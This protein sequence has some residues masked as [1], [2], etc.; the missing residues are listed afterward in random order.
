MVRGNDSSHNPSMTPDGHYVVFESWANNLVPSDTNGTA[1]VLMKDTVTGTLTRV[2]TDSLG[3]QGN[4]HSFYPSISS[5]GRF[6]AFASGASNLVS[7]DTNSRDDVFV[8]DLDTGSIRRVSV[9][10][11]D[12]G[13]NDFSNEPIVSGDGQFVAFA[14]RAT[15]LHAYDN[16]GTN[17]IFRA[18]LADFGDAPDTYGTTMTADGARHVAT[19]LLLGGERDIDSD[20]QLPLDG[21]GD[22]VTGTPDD[23]DGVTFTPMA[24]G[25]SAVV[26][27]TVSGGAGLLDAW[28]DFDGSGT[29][30]DPSERITAAGGTVVNVGANPIMVSI[31]ASAASGVTY[32][33]F[34]LSTT[35]GL[36]PT[37]PASDGEVEDYALSVA[38]P[39]SV[40]V[41]ASWAGTPIGADPPGPATAYG[42]DAF[43]NLPDGVAIVADTGTVN[44]AAGTYVHTGQLDI[45]RAMTIVGAG[46][47]VTIVKR[48]GAATSHEQRTVQIN[49]DNVTIQSLTLG[50]WVDPSDDGDIGSGYL[51]W[52]SSMDHVTFDDVRFDADDNRVAIYTGTSDYLTVTNSRFTGSYFRAGI[53]GAGEHMNISYNSFEESHY[54]YSPIYMEYG[55]PTSGL[56]S[57]NYFANRVGVNNDVEGEFKSDGT[58]LY[59]ITNWQPHMVTA[60]GLRIEYNTFDFQDSDLVNGAGNQPIPVGVMNDPALTASGPITI[61]DNIFRGYQYTGSQPSS[62]T[63]WQ[64]SARPAPYN[65][66]LAFD[67]IAEHAVF[68]SPLL[69][70]GEEGTIAF[71]INPDDVSTQRHALINGGGIEVTLRYGTVYFYPNSAAGDS[72]LTYGARYSFP[73]N[74]WTHVAV[75]WNHATQSTAIYFNGVESGYYSS[76]TPANSSWST[77]SD[78]AGKDIYVGYDPNNGDRIYPGMMDDLGFFDEELS[79]VEVASIMTNGVSSLL[80]DG[81][82]VAAWTLD[83]SSGEV[84]VDAENSIDLQLQNSSPTFVPTGGQIDGALDF[85]ETAPNFG[86]F[87]SPSYDVGSSGTLA[88]WVKPTDVG[89]QRHQILDGGGMGFTIRNSDAYFYAVSGDDDTLTYTNDD[90]IA[91]DT[92]THLAFTWDYATKTTHIYVN[93][94]EA[95][96]DPSYGSARPGWDTE[97]NTADQLIA[98]GIDFSHLDRAFPGLM[99]DIGVFDQPLSQTDIQ[100]VM[101]N[102][103]VALATD[104]RLVTHWNLD[105]APGTLE[106]PSDNGAAITLHL[107]DMAPPPATLA[108]AIKSSPNTTVT[109]NV[110]WEND[111]NFNSSV[112]DGG[113]NQDADPL[114]ADPPAG[115]TTEEVYTLQYHSPAINAATGFIPPPGTNPDERHIGAFQGVPVPPVNTVY[116]DDTWDGTAFGEDP[117]GLGPALFFGVDSFATI[118]EGINGVNDAGTVIVYSHDVAGYDENV[119]IAKELTLTGESG[120]ATDV[121]IDPTSGDGIAISAGGDSVT[122]ADLR[123]TGAA[124]GITASDV[125]TLTL[126]NVQLDN[127]TDDGFDGSSLTGSTTVTDSHFSNNGSEGFYVDSFFDVTIGTTVFDNNTGHGLTLTG[128]GTI[129]LSDSSAN[130]NTLGLDVLTAGSLSV[131]GGS[132]SGNTTE[133]IRVD[134]VTGASSVTGA[135]IQNNGTEGIELT[136]VGVFGVTANTF[137]GNTDYDLEVNATSL[138]DTITVNATSIGFGSTAVTIDGNVGVAHVESLD[139][140]DEIT[141]T[142]SLST[143][144]IIDGG[145]PTAPTTPGDVLNFLTPTGETATLTDP[146]EDSGTILTTNYQDVVF[147]EI[148]RLNFGGNV[149]VDGT[150]DDDLLVIDATGPAAGT[151]QLTT[152]VN[153]SAGGPFVGPIVGLAGVTKFTFN[154]FA[155]DDTFQINNPTGDLFGPVDGIVFNGGDDSDLLQILGGTGTSGSYTVGS[156][157]DEGTLVA[158]DGTTTQTINFTGLELNPIEHTTSLGTFTV[159]ATDDVDTINISDGT[160]IGSDA[161]IEV[162]LNYAFD[163]ILLANKS[164]VNVDGEGEADTINVDYSTAA[165]GLSI[166]NVNGGTNADVINLLQSTPGSV[167]TNLNGNE[168]IDL[169]DFTADVLLTGSINGGGGHD[170][171]DLTAYTSARSVSLSG[172]GATDGYNGT[173]T[174]IT[175]TFTNID[176]VL[177]PTAGGDTLSGANLATTWAVSTDNNGTLSDGIAGIVAA[178]G[179]TVMPI[180][181]GGGQD[182]AFTSFENLTGGSHDDWFDLADGVGIAGALDGGAGNDTLDYRDYTS[183]VTVDLSAGTATSIDGN[184]AA[185]ATGSSIENVFGGSG[186]DTITGDGDANV[187]GDGFGS[188]LLQGGA[189]NDRFVLEPGGT[190]VLNE[191]SGNDTLDFSLAAAGIV[192][193]MDLLN[194]EQDVFGGNTVALNEELPA[195]APSPYENIIGS[196]FDDTINIDPLFVVRNVDGNDPGTLPG[197]LLYFDG[198]TSEVLDTGTSI[199]ASAIGSV[200]Y[201]D[202]EVVEPFNAAARIIDN[203]DPGYSGDPGFI[204]GTSEGYLGDNRGSLSGDGSNVARWTFEGVTPGWH[205]VAVTWPDAGGRVP[206]AQFAVLDGATSATAIVANG[207]S[208]TG[209]ATIDESVAPVGFQ[210]D[211]APW[212]ELANL[213]DPAQPLYFWATGHTLTV[214]LSNLSGNAYAPVIADAVR[215]ERL[216]AEEAEIRIVEQSKGDELITGVGI[217]DFGTTTTDS[218][219]VM[220]FDIQNVGLDDLTVELNDPLPI[221]YSTLFTSATLTPGQSTT[222]TVTLNELNSLTEGVYG[223]TFQL[224]TNDRDENPFRVSVTGLVED[225]DPQPVGTTVVDNDGPGT[226]ASTSG[227][228]YQSDARYVDHDYRY[229]R[230]GS[231]TAT[232][233]FPSLADG[234]YDLAATWYGGSN[235]DSAAP[236]KAVVGTT[237][238]LNVTVDQ[239]QAP[240]DF[241]EE[242]IMWERL[243]TVHVTGGQILSIQLSTDGTTSYV[244]ADAVLATVSTSP[245]IAVFDGTTELI[246]EVSQVEFIPGMVDSKLFTVTNQGGGALTLSEPISVPLGFSLTQSFGQLTLQPGEDTTF[247]VTVNS[248]TPGGTTG[249]LQFG[250]DDTDESVFEFDLTANSGVMI[251]DDG[252]LEF[253]EVGFT[254]Y[255]SRSFYEGDVHYSRKGDGSNYADWHFSGLRADRSY[256]IAAT[257]KAYSTLAS[258]AKYEVYAGDTPSPATLLMTV[259]VDQRINPDDFTDGANWEELTIASGQTDLTIRLSNDANNWVYADAIRL[260]QVYLP[261]V[262]VLIDGDPIPTGSGLDFG[263]LLAGTSATDSI[264]VRNSGVLPLVVSNLDWPSEPGLTITTTGF[265]DGRFDAGESFTIDVVV[266]GTVLSTG[267]HSWNIIFDSNDLSELSC[268]IPIDVEVVDQ[269]IIDN[270]D[271]GFRL[272]AG[273]DFLSVWRD[274]R[275][276]DDDYHYHASGTGVNTVEWEFTDLTPGV[277]NVFATWYGGSNRATD[278]PFTADG[279]AVVQSVDVSQQVAPDDYTTPDGTHWEQLFSGGVTVS[280]NGTLVVELSD[281]ANSYVVADAIMVQYVS[282]LLAADSASP[283]TAS[284]VDTLQV[285]DLQP[286]LAVA[287]DLWLA[288]GLTEAEAARLDAVNVEIAALPGD[289]LGWT[290]IDGASVWIDDDGAGWGW[291]EDVQI[292]ITDTVTSLAKDEMDLLTVLAHELGH[293]IGRDHGAGLMESHLEAGVRKLPDS[294]PQAVDALFAQLDDDLD[295]EE[296]EEDLQLWDALYG[297][298]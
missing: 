288:T 156:G 8:K 152:D 216:N 265:G 283:S 59:A 245:E 211:G 201:Q 289:V 118:Q 195:P 9:D 49:A 69:D 268:T 108:Y 277:Y 177:A 113:S 296:E 42:Y 181:S 187:L 217:Q 3:N 97:A 90:S 43:D 139:G 271:P 137:S 27:V 190:D 114:F 264:E 39:S 287:K 36:A 145:N 172:I 239:T 102:G 171:I 30:D 227:F 231:E 222:L 100:N 240:N 65:G 21:T 184:V 167:T 12:N 75:S 166:L 77:P 121:V 31:P 150:A 204:L 120:A 248:D 116:V 256:Q 229:A 103:V 176:E 60:D 67:G 193:D 297:L 26:T 236:F 32:A 141:L 138:G 234:W 225:A 154:G 210:S 38:A 272:G 206:D 266:D 149:V 110:F 224:D 74:T 255:A 143:K 252:D 18:S 286:V 112:T 78:P 123:V 199:T 64:P 28:I 185:G 16:A 164:T 162:D 136:T 179:R 46:Q 175:G 133:G 238:V 25:G 197:D 263:S 82:L 269:L 157:A 251:V 260:E 207:A 135:T 99:D 119:I 11:L 111:V 128:G 80:G 7:G 55:A 196:A 163:S 15:N 57:H 142:P 173:E 58:G 209:I 285:A 54:W 160:P 188:D 262:T 282:P 280:A 96:Y 94:V 95:G 47:D 249:R 134:D 56:I 86:T 92:W 254:R 44:V 106:V 170:T 22:D 147:D 291:Y 117:D 202:I 257:W 275:Y 88:L 19:G 24:P 5:D 183:S 81:R 66:A 191:E 48:D 165:A 161:T 124:D 174:A 41:D 293:V 168:G 104:G 125:S 242:G 50:G 246:D 6:V 278:A 144:F 192:I 219:S 232:W 130:G 17:D 45:D 107:Q 79:E 213:A 33:R 87:R 148:E 34:R 61:A 180:R 194:V 290:T 261:E 218:S 153:G 122:I 63:G 228:L 91:A 294:T 83:Q 208:A 126:D 159:N 259:E 212:Q 295:D 250:S 1:E 244:C 215:I 214:E 53:R 13:G 131:T 241:P 158:T 2:G 205:R 68:N 223:G 186:G 221:G 51:A 243:G 220:T 233:T 37:G 253:A 284:V 235:R 279:G 72:A 178:N 200:L 40:Y 20:A 129:A 71:W 151:F 198:G 226:F 89:G 29:F 267:A 35:G 127:N 230:G 109:N 182:L 4:G 258:N 276:F 76:Y 101:N 203:D 169:F 62:P 146:G 292:T 85:D 23:E 247:E 155:G 52:T 98:L 115:T 270:G 140:E 298:E 84:A 73:A 93:G 189:G 70:I 105:N 273:S 281:D 14:S 237:E 10:A 274:T 132:F